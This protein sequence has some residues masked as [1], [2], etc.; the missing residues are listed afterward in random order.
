LICLSGF[1]PHSPH[2]NLFYRGL[3]DIMRSSFY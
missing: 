3:K 1:M 2:Y